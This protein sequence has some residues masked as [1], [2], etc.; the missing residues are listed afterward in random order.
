MQKSALVSLQVSLQLYERLLSIIYLFYFLC[1][2]FSLLSLYLKWHLANTRKIV[3]L[4]LKEKRGQRFTSQVL[5]H[6]YA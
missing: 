2:S 6:K 5:I 4:P 3:L 1:L